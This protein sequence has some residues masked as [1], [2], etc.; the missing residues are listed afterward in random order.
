MVSASATKA[1]LGIRTSESGGNLKVRSTERDGAAYLQGL[2]VDDEIIAA[3]NFRVTSNGELSEI[4]QYKKVGD[5]VTLLIARDGL[6]QTLILKLE[7]DDTKGYRI[8]KIE[9]PSKNQQKV[10]A[11][12]FEKK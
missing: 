4:L 9:N 7:A 12:W 5:E 10:Y 8:D 2:N 3:D 6:L 11:K 1:T